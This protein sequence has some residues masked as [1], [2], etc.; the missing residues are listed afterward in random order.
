MGSR[1]GQC[2]GEPGQRGVSVIR[3][4]K[5]YAPRSRNVSGASA[6]PPLSP[7]GTP[8]VHLQIR[9]LDDDDNKVETKRDDGRA[10]TVSLLLVHSCCLL[11]VRMQSDAEVTDVILRV[12]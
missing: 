10:R 2:S 6:F 12:V 11:R 3:C 1:P 8:A 4:A 9:A 5:L 7:F